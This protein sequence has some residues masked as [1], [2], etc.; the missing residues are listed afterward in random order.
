VEVQALWLNA[1]HAASAIDAAWGH[2]LAR[3]TISFNDRF[4]N[5]DRRI[6]Y[7]VVDVNHARG[8][9]DGTL[10]PNQILA[11]GGLP[12]PIVTNGR[13]R[14]IVDAVEQHLWTPLGLR[15]LGRMEPGYVRRYEGDGAR[16]DAAY[17]QGT[18][19]PWLTGPFVDAWLRVRAYTGEARATA[20]RRFVAPLE[21]HLDEAG[22]GH[23]SEIADGDDP[24][25]PRGCPFQAWSVGELIRAK[26]MVGGTPGNRVGSWALSVGS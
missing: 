6:L 7:D 5:A 2:V 18:V 10:R 14:V 9:S 8:V 22:L 24:F 17:H 25:T 20:S 3:G 4:W 11:I 26:Q 1:L 23:V 21:D 19:W 15:S 16:R 13:A 12:L